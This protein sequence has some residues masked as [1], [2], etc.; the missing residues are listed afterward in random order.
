M[1][2]SEIM[3]R[4]VEIK[5]KENPK[6]PNGKNIAKAL[7]EEIVKIEEESGLRAINFAFLGEKE[8]PMEGEDSF[9][10]HAVSHDKVHAYMLYFA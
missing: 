2:R 4:Y 7:K 8:L 10:C 9:F 1:T 6:E 3:M 5:D